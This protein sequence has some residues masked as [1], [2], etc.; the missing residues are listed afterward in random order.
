MPGRPS[1]RSFL[2]L[3]SHQRT[4]VLE[5][6][7]RHCGYVGAWEKCVLGRRGLGAKRCGQWWGVWGE[8]RLRRG[9]GGVQKGVVPCGRGLWWMCP[10]LGAWSMGSV[11]MVGCHPVN[12][13]FLG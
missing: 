4:F 11:P 12:M 13:A 3:R 2:P 1:S 5:V 8:A 7:G 6:M 9:H 10:R